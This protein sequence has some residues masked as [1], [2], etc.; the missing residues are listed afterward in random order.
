M[1]RFDIVLNCCTVNNFCY[2]YYHKIQTALSFLNTDCKIIHNNVNLAS[3]VVNRAGEWKLTGFEFA[4]GIDDSH[5]PYKCL[6]SLDCYEPPERSPVSNLKSTPSRDSNSIEQ[7]H[8]A[9]SWGLG[10]LIWEIFN[11][12]L[13][14]LNALKN[15]GNV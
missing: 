11:G 10:C 5:T 2:Y 7:L 1:N 8:S 9:D 14:N 3:V 4:H 15:P 6:P 13:P 12:F